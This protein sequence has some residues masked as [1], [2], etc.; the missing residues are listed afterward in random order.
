MT[1]NCVAYLRIVGLWEWWYCVFLEREKIIYE[2]TQELISFIKRDNNKTVCDIIK[3]CLV[4]MWHTMPFFWCVERGNRS[5]QGQFLSCHRQ[6]SWDETTLAPLTSPSC[7]WC[8]S[9]VL[10]LLAFWFTN[11]FLSFFSLYFSFI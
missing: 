6:E 7:P 10:T 2:G 1:K 3:S 9:K 4:T 11:F 8:K 5:K